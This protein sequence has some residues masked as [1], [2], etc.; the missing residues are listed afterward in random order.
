MEFS[1]RAYGHY[2]LWQ[3]RSV[4]SRRTLLRI[5]QKVLSTASGS[6]NTS[7]AP[8]L[9]S[10]IASSEAPWWVI[11]LLRRSSWVRV[12]L[13]DRPS[14]NREKASSHMPRAFHSSTSLRG[15]TRNRCSHTGVDAAVRGFQPSDLTAHEIC[16]SPPSCY[17]LTK[18][19]SITRISCVYLVYYNDKI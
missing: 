14:Q 18:N 10:T 6:P 2:P 9:F 12:P 1:P 16:F 5:F 17:T 15:Q 13:A 11:W 19:V 8:F 3:G 7:R 4:P